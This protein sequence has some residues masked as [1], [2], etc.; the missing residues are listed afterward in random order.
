MVALA[1]CAREAL[2]HLRSV[3]GGLLCH[4]PLGTAHPPRGSPR[5]RPHGVRTGRA[6]PP[7]PPPH[8]PARAPA[9]PRGPPAPPAPPL[10]LPP[11]PPAPGRAPGGR[12]RVALG[13]GDTPP[14]VIGKGSYLDELVTL[15]GT[16][17]VFHDLGSASATVALETIAA[18]NPD[19]IVVLR[20]SLEPEPLRFARRREWQV[21]PAVRA[22]RLGYLSGS[23]FWR[24]GPRAAAAGAPFRPRLAG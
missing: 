12:G 9:R 16:E 17:N 8:R 15:A 7:P 22:R 3:G 11:P 5:P 13:V 10:A 18:R 19:A 1:H 20:D 14:V 21:G 24:P 23:L 6:P 2:A 4:A